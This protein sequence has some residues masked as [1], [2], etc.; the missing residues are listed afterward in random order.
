MVSS[1]FN[2]TDGSVFIRT[3]VTFLV[4]VPPIIKAS[5]FASAG[6]TNVSDPIT[7]EAGFRHGNIQKNL[8]PHLKDMH[9]FG[10]NL[11]CKFDAN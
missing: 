10:Q 5:G 2:A 11:S 8:V 6:R 7:I 1:A 9:A 3:R 4:S